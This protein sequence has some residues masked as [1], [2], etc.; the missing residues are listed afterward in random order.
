MS[1]G[2]GNPRYPQK[3][4]RAPQTCSPGI[5]QVLG[6]TEHPPLQPSAWGPLER[7]LSQ[8]PTPAG[9]QVRR[10][11]P[12]QREADRGSCRSAHSGRA[13]VWLSIGCLYADG[14]LSQ[15][16]G[17]QIHT[18]RPR[19]L[20]SHVGLSFIRDPSDP[21]SHCGPWLVLEDAESLHLEVP[22]RSGP[23]PPRKPISGG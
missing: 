4:F 20:C 15:S 16:E 1:K 3:K 14:P 12:S 10:N 8:P 23:A 17:E 19:C 22:V 5:F 9:G 6:D 21:V 18:R 11:R 2:R 13:S 7:C